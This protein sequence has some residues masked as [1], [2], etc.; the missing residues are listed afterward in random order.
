MG[1]L[2]E[3]EKYLTIEILGNIKVAAFKVDKKKENEPDYRGNGIAIWV[4]EKKRKAIPP[5]AEKREKYYTKDL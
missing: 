5:V 4:N 3:G 2:K 1:E